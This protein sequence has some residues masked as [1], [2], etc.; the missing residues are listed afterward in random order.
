MTMW[1]HHG[2]VRDTNRHETVRREGRGINQGIGEIDPILA[3]GGVIGTR[4]GSVASGGFAKG[5]DGGE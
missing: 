2:F 1:T 5:K 4:D 3:D